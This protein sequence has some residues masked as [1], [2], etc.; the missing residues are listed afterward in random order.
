VPALTVVPR[1]KMLKARAA[2]GGG[3]V[4][5]SEVGLRLGCRWVLAGGFQKMG[6][7]LRLTARLLE[8]ATGRIVSSIKLDATIDRIFELQDRVAAEC[9][10]ALN[11]STPTLDEGAPRA[12]PSLSAYEAYARGRRLWMRL[13][14]G[15]FE[16]AGQLY[17]QAVGLEPGY[18]DALAG[19]AAVHAMRFT[20]TTD[21]AD[22][23]AATDYARRA[24]EAD[25][26]SGEPHVWLGYALLRRGAVEEAYQEELT[27]IRLSPSLHFAHYFAGCTRL[28]AGRPAEA[29]RHFRQATEIEPQAG[30][31][32]LGLGWTFIDLG[33]LEQARWSFEKA[34]T[35]EDA[36]V[37]PP[38]GAASYAAEA[39]RRQ[40]DATAAR[41]EALVGLERIERSDHMYR[42][43]FRAFSLCV[44]GRAALD[45]GDAAAAGTAFGQ[46]MLHL[47]GRPRALGGGH[48]M[49]QA[50]AGLARATADPRALDEAVRLFEA[51]DAFDFSW[52]YGCA[53]AEDARDLTLAADALGRTELA[54]RLR[55][56]GPG[57]HGGERGG[58]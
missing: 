37:S 44:L 46:A 15:S 45:E 42:D 31:D 52:F 7:A 53:D 4:D 1:D 12:A 16:E 54:R 55:A 29:L 50:G 36:A 2:A 26:R 19:L 39:L 57:T 38:V 49:V 8:A 34:R 25:P 58:R 3:P 32:W 14:K 33:Q 6:T 10:A 56:E 20:F 43:T 9:I 41:R 48:L 40:G 11:L 30:F 47:R 17:R 28:T 51:R 13:E 5:A 22:L 23:D 24:V 35:L 18:A 21:R 27:A